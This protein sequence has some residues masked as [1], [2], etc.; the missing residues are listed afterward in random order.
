MS[1]HTFSF[2]FS[3]VF[4]DDDGE[5]LVTCGSFVKIQHKDTKY[6]LSSE[7]KQLG[8]GSGQQIVTFVEDPSTHNTLW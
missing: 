8:G 4:L 7:E 2:P 1:A 5:N 6:Y 3:L